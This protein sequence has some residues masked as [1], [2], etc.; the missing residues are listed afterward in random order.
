MLN[1]RSFISVIIFITA[2]MSF[3]IVPTVY[4]AVTNIPQTGQTTSYYPRDDGDLMTGIAWPTAG[5]MGSGRFYDNSDGTV[6]D[7]LTGLIWTKNANA[8]GLVNFYAARDAADAM[9][10]AGYTDWRIPNILELESLLHAG[11]S[12]T[13]AWLNS[14]GFQNVQAA[15]YWSSNAYADDLYA[16]WTINF[17]TNTNNT[18]QYW[19]TAAKYYWAVRAGQADSSDPS[20][21]ANVRKTG[22]IS[23]LTTGDDGDLQWGVTWPVPRFEDTDSEAGTKTD[24]FSGLMWMTSG[25]PFLNLGA[26]GE[27]HSFADAM[28]FIEGIN[29]SDKICRVNPALRAQCFPWSGQSLPQTN[30]PAD[31]ACQ[32][33]VLT[34]NQWG[35]CFGPDVTYCIDDSYCNDLENEQ[36]VQLQNYGYTDWH[37]P[38]LKEIY[39]MTKWEGEYASDYLES[40]GFTDLA[41][42]NPNSYNPH[43]TSTTDPSNTNNAFRVRIDIAQGLI[44]SCAKDNSDCLSRVRALY[45]WP[46]RDGAVACLNLNAIIE[47]Q[48]FQSDSLQEAYTTANNDAVIKSQAESFIEDLNVNAAKT[49]YLRAGYDCDYNEPPSGSTNIFGNVTVSL[50][51]LIIET[52]QVGVF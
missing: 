43:W 31:Y 19:D 26:S 24:T 32:G 41:L 7:L 36:C 29:A 5:N 35:E 10:T 9:T 51:T 23:S 2:F 15:E 39:S 1:I 28:E 40:Q 14:E 30:C 49:V 20:Y 13:A 38:N 6:T 34:P 4:S 25:N 12:D 8:G 42:S 27:I 18:W 37:M 21:P 3:I 45:V 17:G 44:A 16:G 52:G 46:V 50:G 47:S 33:A 48:S 11:A 22:K